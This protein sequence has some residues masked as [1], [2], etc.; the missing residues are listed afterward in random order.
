M[1][2]YHIFIITLCNMASL[3]ASKVLV[4]L[5]AIELGAN[6]F[7]IGVLV[8]MYS[9]FPMLLA[10][11]AGRL[12]DRFGVVVPMT[13]GSFGAACGLLVPYLFPVLPGLYASAA[14]IG[15]SFVFYHVSIQ[16][17]MGILSAPHE[18]TRNFASYSLM[19]SVGGFLGPLIAGFGIDAL[20]HARTYLVLAALPLV[21][22]VILLATAG[23]IPRPRAQRAEEG[24]KKLGDLWRNAPLRRVFITSGVVLT[25]IDLYQFYMP[26][27]GHSVGLSASV[28]GVVLSMFAAAGFV[29]RAV[30]P[31]L[32]RKA[33]EETLLTYALLLGAATY[34]AMPFFS[35]AWLLGMM[36]FMLGLGLGCG[37]PLSMMLTFSRSPSGRSGEALGM[38]LAVNNFTHVVVPLVFGTVGTAFG[39]LPVFWINAALLAGGGYVMRGGQ[40]T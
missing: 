30:I 12:S 11:H 19:L 20:G 21:P 39:L 25:G 27:H 6:P 3:R 14:A 13:L 17:L 1:T 10:L 36:S 40:R 23:R 8:A 35:S 7:G 37:Q 15:A 28:I 32:V 4:T 16:N 26:I 34:L 18:R 31:A 22:V 9:V 33:G 5:F 38:R 24:A 2:I 29:V